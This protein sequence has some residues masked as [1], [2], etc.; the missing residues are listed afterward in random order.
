MT[1]FSVTWC[2]P[3]EG[4]WWSQM[5]KTGGEPLRLR[6]SIPSNRNPLL[7][8]LPCTP[9]DGREQPRNNTWRRIL[10]GMQRVWFSSLYF[11]SFVMPK[12]KSKGRLWG[13]WS[14]AKNDSED[15][16]A[17]SQ[18]NSSEKLAVRDRDAP[19]RHRGRVST[20]YLVSVDFIFASTLATS[21][22]FWIVSLLT[23]DLCRSHYSIPPVW[24]MIHGRLC[25]ARITASSPTCETCP[26]FGNGALSAA[27]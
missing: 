21:G 6:V 15:Q 23:S 12:K 20:T 13:G 7:S 25:K 5:K 18:E 10:F 2:C 1:L 26:S 11:F 16:G 8:L 4:C 24:S 22:Q 19:L 17:L 9:R 3:T 14:L 27:T